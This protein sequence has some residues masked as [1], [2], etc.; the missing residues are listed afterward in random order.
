MGSCIAA[1]DVQQ[2]LSLTYL[3]VVHTDPTS[4]EAHP[5]IWPLLCFTERA[6]PIQVQADPFLQQRA[7]RSR[8]R[9]DFAQ[10][11]TQPS[12]TGAHANG[13]ASSLGFAQWSNPAGG[14]RGRACQCPGL[15]RCHRTTVVIV[16]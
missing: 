13:A 5:A 6:V 7:A 4:Q 12:S 10:D 1:W 14:K 8:S 11:D 2:A 16:T 15:Q 9:F 3:G